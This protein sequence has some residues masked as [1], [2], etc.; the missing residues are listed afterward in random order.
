MPDED[1]VITTAYRCEWVEVYE[2]DT[3]GNPVRGTFRVIAE[4][5]L[6]RNPSDEQIETAL[7][8]ELTDDPPIPVYVDAENN[9]LV[10]V[11][12]PPEVTY[13]RLVE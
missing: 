4:A 7:G 12:P 5:E 3:A 2:R 8:T 9:R 1:E 10:A 13:F 6:P 11:P